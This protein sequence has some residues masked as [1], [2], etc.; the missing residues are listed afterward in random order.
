MELKYLQDITWDDIPK[1][2]SPFFAIANVEDDLD[3]PYQEITY[4][5]KESTF[6]KIYNK[7]TREVNEYELN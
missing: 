6:D 3:D 1:I 4:S 5:I 7:V 2:E